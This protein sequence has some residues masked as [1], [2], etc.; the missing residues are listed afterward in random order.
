MKTI[1]AI[2]DSAINIKVDSKFKRK[3]ISYGVNFTHRNEEHINFFGGQLLGVDR[4]LFLDS[5]R[6]DWIDGIL[7]LD[8]PI[9]TQRDIKELPDIVASRVVSGDLMNLTLVFM[10]HRTMHSGLSQRDKDLVTV[11]LINI[12]QYKLFTSMHRHYFSEKANPD[13]AMA[14]YEGLSR[15][16]SIKRLGTWQAV[17]TNRSEDIVDDSSIWSHALLRFDNNDDIVKMLNDIQ[18]R[19]KSILNHLTDD[20]NDTIRLGARISSADKFITLE[21]EQVIKDTVNSYTLLND[22]MNTMMPSRLDFINFDTVDTVLDV[23]PSADRRY[24][25]ATLEYMSDNYNTAQG[26]IIIELIDSLMQFLFLV[27][28][29][30]NLELKQV[31]AVM[32]K[33]RGRLKSNRIRNPLL[34]KAKENVTAIV[35]IATGT[36]NR[37]ILAGVRAATML[38]VVLR[39]I[40][41]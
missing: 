1:K 24:L 7:H 33:M 4:V 32:I 2:L 22:R 41:N 30:S 5:D 13:I 16:S 14:M 28:Q 35:E 3:V 27:V 20:F 21:G 11:G 18:G 19:L 8:D 25:L 36:E 12:L 29:E 15:K 34:L 6:E 10:V 38:Y 39:S 9:A 26:Q 40:T 17:F 31:V 23:M 37:N